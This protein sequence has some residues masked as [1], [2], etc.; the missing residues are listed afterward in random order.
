[1]NEMTFQILKIVI[2]VCFCMITLYA[3]PYAH[4]LLQ[5][6]KLGEALKVVNVAVLAAEQSVQG[7]G[8]GA[9]KKEMAVKYVSDWLSS[10]S[11]RITAEQIDGL[12]E[13]AV[14]GLKTGKEL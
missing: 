1:M 9:I 7:A 13:A 8:K 2:S 12:V 10:H 14:Y 6:E 4:R 3:I 11:I 5:N